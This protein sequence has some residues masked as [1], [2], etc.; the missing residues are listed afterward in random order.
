MA[1]FIVQWTHQT[2]VGRTSP[3][4]KSLSFPV[5]TW[6]LHTA[7]SEFIKG[8]KQKYRRDQRPLQLIINILI[9]I[10]SLPSSKWSLKRKRVIT[11]CAFTYQTGANWSLQ[12]LILSLFSKCSPNK[13]LSHGAASIGI[14]QL[15]ASGTGLIVPNSDFR[16]RSVLCL[17]VRVMRNC[18][19][20]NNGCLSK[21]QP[22]SSS[23][24]PTSIP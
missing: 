18:F 21:K 22:P 13:A 19:D 1:I 14:K 3:H 24:L 23:A 11:V 6:T 10:A 4:T 9:I 20:K 15:T 7:G 5:F 12:S 17:S 2:P 8:D 16:A